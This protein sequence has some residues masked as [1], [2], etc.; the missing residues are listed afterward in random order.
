M[1]EQEKI[2]DMDFMELEHNGGQH[3]SEDW[4]NLESRCYQCHQI[5]KSMQ[6]CRETSQGLSGTPIGYKAVEDRILDR[7]PR[8]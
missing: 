5:I 3:T 6:R 4:K 1:N 7:D 8:N 2:E